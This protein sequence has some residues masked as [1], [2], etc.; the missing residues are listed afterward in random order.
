[1]LK[2]IKIKKGEKLHFKP[3]SLRSVKKKKKASDG[4][5]TKEKRDRER[6]RVK[7]RERE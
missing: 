3:Y 4:W 7:T 6:I 2:T 1:M 5:I